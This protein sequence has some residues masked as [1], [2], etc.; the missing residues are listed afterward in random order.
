[1]E[2]A[3]LIFAITTWFAVASALIVVAILVY[4]LLL[5]ETISRRYWEFFNRAADQTPGLQQSKESWPG[6]RIGK[7]VIWPVSPG[8]LCTG[9]SGRPASG[10]TPMLSRS[11]AAALG[12]FGKTGRILRDEAERKTIP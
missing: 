12:S 5:V 1:M 9:L 3:A 7:P 4:L 10:S 8:H 2:K 6:C 11:M